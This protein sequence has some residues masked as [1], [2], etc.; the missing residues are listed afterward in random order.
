MGNFRIGQHYDEA[1]RTMQPLEIKDNL[2]A[3]AYGIQEKSYTKNLTEEHFKI[4]VEEE[5]EKIKD[6]VTIIEY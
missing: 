3:I 2:E 5:I 1:L 4:R 6:F